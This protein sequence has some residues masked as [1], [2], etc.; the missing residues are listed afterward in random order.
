MMVKRKQYLPVPGSRGIERKVACRRYAI[1]KMN[2]ENRNSNAGNG[3]VP[4]G[5]ICCYQRAESEDGV[6]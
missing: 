5:T 6:P 2:N 3:F 4:L 1:E